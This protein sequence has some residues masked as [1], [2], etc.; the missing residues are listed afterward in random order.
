MSNIVNCLFVLFSALY[1][2]ADWHVLNGE[3]V[4]RLVGHVEMRTCFTVAGGESLN[5]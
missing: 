1:V 5:L 3:F 2:Q 4:R